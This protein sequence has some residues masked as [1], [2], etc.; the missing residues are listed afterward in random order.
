MVPIA[1]A[2]TDRANFVLGLPE[3]QNRVAISRRKI[4][5][6]ANHKGRVP[7]LAVGDASIP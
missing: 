6:L 2:Q 7:A 5:S 3:V 4:V 1:C